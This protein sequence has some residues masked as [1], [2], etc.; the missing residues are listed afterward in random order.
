MVGSLLQLVLSLLLAHTAGAALLGQ[1]LFFVAIANLATAVGAGM[2]NLMLRYASATRTE[3]V[4]QIGWLWRHS[5]E[6]SL[7]CSASAIAF[8]LSGVSL[9]RDAALAVSALLVQRVSSAVLKAHHHPSL[10]VL[11]DTAFYPLIVIAAA[12]AASAWTH[13]VPIEVLRLSY[14]GA[15][16]GAT[17][18]AATLTWRSDGSV[19]TALSAPWRTARSM[20]AEIGAVTLGAVA[21]VVSSNAPLAMAPIFLTDRQT[22]AFGLALRVA[23]FATTILL[24]LSAYFGP[25]FVRASSR[26]E[27]VDLRRRSQY[28]CLALYLPVP[29]AVLVL[30]AGWLENIDPGLSSIKG[31]VLILSVGFFVN[32]ATGLA[33]TLLLM[34][35]WSRVFSATSVVTAVL[36]VLA[37]AVGGVISGLVGMSAGLSAAMAATNLWIFAVATRHLKDM[38]AQPALGL[39]AA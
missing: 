5:I 28:A 4:P 33:P 13:A 18:I 15:L 10:G 37:L 38:T 30:P 3:Q 34:R 32:A 24:S 11:L 21:N 9:C 25:A 27:L 17:L 39:G 26:E 31:L 7:L 19:R 1:F 6:L 23:G 36:T 16:W 8:G 35:G 22:G 14:V 29:I 20:Y 12:L 2:P